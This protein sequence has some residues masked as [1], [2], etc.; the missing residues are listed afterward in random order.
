MISVI[1]LPRNV[2]PLCTKGV[3]ERAYLPEYSPAS[4]KTYQRRSEP[5]TGSEDTWA[6]QHSQ[7]NGLQ[8]RTTWEHPVISQERQKLE[9]F[10]VLGF[11]GSPDI[12]LLV[13]I[14]TDRKKGYMQH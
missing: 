2:L 11:Q 1:K 3:T 8:N 12:K 7:M 13:T 10:T 14:N 6:A 4:G 9:I 5:E